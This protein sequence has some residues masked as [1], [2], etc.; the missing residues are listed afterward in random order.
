MG[1]VDNTVLYLIIIG[2]LFIL[3]AIILGKAFNIPD[4]LDDITG[5]KAKRQLKQLKKM[6]SS[7][8]LLQ[9]M[10]T[11]DVYR[12]LQESKNSSSVDSS[13]EQKKEKSER[14]HEKPAETK[15][16][17][18]AKRPEKRKMPEAQK[19]VVEE[20]PDFEVVDEQPPKISKSTV[21]TPEE[22]SDSRDDLSVF[23]SEEE[24]SRVSRTG[25]I[26]SIHNI[27][28]VKRSVKILEEQSSI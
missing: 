11:G 23:I 26:S 8:G 21:H 14:T 3:I 12:A 5:R 28:D 18:N 25:V 1:T 27:G 2:G 13:S 22:D 15:Q 24:L 7:T 16:L 17:T 10:S 9:S 6:N 20:E 19:V 4:I